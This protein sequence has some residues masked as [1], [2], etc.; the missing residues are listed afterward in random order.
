MNFFIPIVLLG[1]LLAI[2]LLLIL[3]D[4]LLGGKGEK[5]LI[6]NNKTNIPVQGD[7]TVLNVLSRNKIFIPSACGGK[8]TC[9]LCKCKVTEGGGEI[10]PTEDPFL[11]KSERE[12]NIRLSCQVKV[13]D[14]MKIEIPESMLN[15]QE[16]KTLVDKVDDLTYDTKLVRLKLINPKTMEFKPGQYAQ[17][18]VPGIEV[19]RAYSIASHPKHTDMI[20]FIIRMV[21]KGKATTFV[22]KALEVGD[23][24]I[25][26][27]PYGDFFLQEDSN[28]DM[29]CIAG[30]SG[31]APIR[32]IL[33]YLRDQGMPRKVKYFFGAKAVRDLYYTEEF[34]KLA[35]E[36]PNFEYI[37]ALSEPDEGDDWDG[38][39]GLIT[40]VV[41][42][43]T[44]DLNEAEAYLCGSPGMID[45][46]IKVL[47]K[48]DIPDKQVF[49]DK[50]S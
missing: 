12:N 48:H 14:Q 32:S 9:G 33:Y 30:G 38:E 40:D 42:R 25:V 4:V 37:P 29:I 17:L 46:C 7:D 41:D 31:K 27:G 21:P 13:R 15:A 47:K 24:V 1:V 3:A 50:F 10:K 16:Y 26:T 36:F 35:E 2:T 18:K 5:A 20:E 19:I 45:A 39:V 44:G 49:Y 43:L 6:I 8:A 22:H 34:M 28:R 23:K 11:S